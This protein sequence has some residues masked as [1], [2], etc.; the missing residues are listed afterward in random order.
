VRYTKAKVETRKTVREVSSPMC[1]HSRN[2]RAPITKACIYNYEC[3]HCP[4][5]Q[6]IEAVEDGCEGSDILVQAA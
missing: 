3:W 6:W 5:D 4:F 2:G 1:F